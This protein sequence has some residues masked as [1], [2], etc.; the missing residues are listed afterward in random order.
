MEEER[1][2]TEMRGEMAEVASWECSRAAGVSGRVAS[3]AIGVGAVAE[4]RRAGLLGMRGRWAV[5]VGGVKG[6]V[7]A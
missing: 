1:Q 5:S 2:Q 6:L 7:P 4:G 3:R